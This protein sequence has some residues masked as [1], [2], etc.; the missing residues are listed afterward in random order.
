MKYLTSL[1]QPGLNKYATMMGI[2]YT[3][4]EE[5]RST[6]EIVINENHF[7]PGMIAHG[8]VAYSLADSTMAM[9]MLSTCKA[10][11]NAS[12]VECKMSYLAPV[13]EGVMKAESWVVKRGKW[14]AFLESRIM[15]GERLIATATATFAVVDLK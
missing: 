1:N 12:T 9:A 15:E 2:V 7:H 3:S 13:T 10:G 11:E 4:V 8:G 6:G 14:I 5:G